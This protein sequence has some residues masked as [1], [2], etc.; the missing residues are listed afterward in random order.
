[1]VDVV[2]ISDF[3]S[4]LIVSAGFVSEKSETELVTILS[5]MVFAS[6]RK[7]SN[8]SNVETL[9]KEPTRD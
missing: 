8:E 5:I 2:Q 7:L 3:P 6:I 1:M 4:P 9:A